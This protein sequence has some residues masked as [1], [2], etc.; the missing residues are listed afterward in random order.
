MV[1]TLWY[2][3]EFSRII[4]I[5]RRR[6]QSPTWKNT[7]P[8]REPSPTWNDITSV[9][10]KLSAPPKIKFPVHS[11]LENMLENFFKMTEVQLT[12]GKLLLIGIYWYQS[13]SIRFIHSHL[14]IHSH[15]D[16]F[17]IGYYQTRVN[18]F[19]EF[20]SNITDTFREL[21]PS[22]TALFQTSNNT[23][24]FR[25]LLPNNTTHFSKAY[26]KHYWHFQG[27][28]DKQYYTLLQS[29]YQTILIFSKS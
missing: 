28:I 15:K 11:N 24:I 23:E 13:T 29:S 7:I 4:F 2:L 9:S 20:I 14:F 26:I 22:K 12:I 10:A 3:L 21:L 18:T 27:F 6:V 5:V 1:G 19:S 25:E 8:P 16:G 17:T